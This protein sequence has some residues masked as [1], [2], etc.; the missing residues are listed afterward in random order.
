MRALIRGWRK[1]W[2]NTNLPFYYVQLPQWHSYAWT[3]AREE[4][5]RALDEPKT[6]MVVTVDLDFNNDIHPPN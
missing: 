3:Y 6:G 1:S 2:D 4:Q 5:L